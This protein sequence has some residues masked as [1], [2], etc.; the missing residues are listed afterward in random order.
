MFFAFHLTILKFHA[1]L[2]YLEKNLVWYKGKK[3]KEV[4]PG[5]GLEI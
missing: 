2:F 3:D 4:T 1:I 5:P